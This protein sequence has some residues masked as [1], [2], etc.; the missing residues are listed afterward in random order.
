MELAS[1][2]K[3]RLTITQKVEENEKTIQHLNK[4][5]HWHRKHLRLID[6]QIE[7]AKEEEPSSVSDL[8]DIAKAGL[9]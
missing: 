6:A 9:K 4:A 8:L 5:N 2:H 3:E 7:E 1:L